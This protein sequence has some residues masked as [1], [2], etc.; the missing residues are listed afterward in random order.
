[1]AFKLTKVNQLPGQF[2]SIV[3]DNIP[4]P[5]QNPVNLWYTDQRADER[6]LE[7]RNTIPTI[8]DK[9]FYTVGEIAVKQGD[10]FWH[11][12]API[13]ILSCTAQI[14]TS[15]TGN[16]LQVVVTK[17]TGA[18]PSDTLYDLDILPSEF[19]T[20]SN[21]PVQLVSGDYIRIDILQTGSQVSGSDLT[22]SFAYKNILQG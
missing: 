5:E 9:H 17:N 22:V 14:K 8:Q 1:M 2:I 18:N 13:E 20:T 16:K 15:P 10:L 6:I 11:I 7:I 19:T 21:S 3:T 12:V 4:E